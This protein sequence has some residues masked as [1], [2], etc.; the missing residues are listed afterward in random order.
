M[1]IFVNDDAGCSAWLARRP[2]SA[3]VEGMRDRTARRLVL[4][5]G[6]CSRLKKSLGRGAATTG[7]RWTACALEASESIAWC[8]GEYGAEPTPCAHCSHREATQVDG[9][10]DDSARDDVDDRNHLTRLGRDI[11]DYVLDV[12][13]IHLEPDIRP[14][15]LTLGDLAQCLRKSP[16][17]LAGQLERLVED[18]LLTVGEPHGR[19]PDRDETRLIHPTAAALRKLEYYA[20]RDRRTVA[21]DLARLHEADAQA[22]GKLVGSR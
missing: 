20:A 19:G 2:R 17:Q 6:D 18:G 21:K 10:D 5:A 7:G 11:L 8:L 12:A 13:V 4:H 9:A 3:C 15:R 22:N 1:L 14:Y 16:R